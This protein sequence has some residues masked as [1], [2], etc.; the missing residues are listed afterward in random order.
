V[1]SSPDSTVIV[2][3]DWVTKERH[4]FT[5]ANVSHHSLQARGGIAATTKYG[6]GARAAALGL[7]GAR[8]LLGALRP[9]LKTRAVEHDERSHLQLR[10]ALQ[11]G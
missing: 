8:E 7:S 3:G 1:N 9:R 6:D 11:V 4:S 10:G 2:G 5:S